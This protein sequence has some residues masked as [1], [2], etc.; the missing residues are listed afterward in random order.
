MV[1]WLAHQ[2]RVLASD[3]LGPMG[4]LSRGM[5]FAEGMIGVV[6]VVWCLFQTDIKDEITGC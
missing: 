3:W 6:L 2:E 4:W 1:Y 5:P